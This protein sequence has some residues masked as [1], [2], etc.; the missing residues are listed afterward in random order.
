MASVWAAGSARILPIRTLVPVRSK[1]DGS[2]K[3]GPV[4]GFRVQGFGFRVGFFFQL[5]VNP[6]HRNQIE[7]GTNT[8]SAAR[9]SDP[10]EPKAYLHISGSPP[11]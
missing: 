11:S 5:L 6:N 7:R 3:K 2:M 8:T 9:S 1:E 10:T 4:L